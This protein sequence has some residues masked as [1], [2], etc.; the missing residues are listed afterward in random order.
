MRRIEEEKTRSIPITQA[1]VKKAYKKVRS[2]H[3]SAGVDQVSMEEYQA[4]LRNN[5]YKLWNRLSSG[6]YFPPPVQEVTIP[7]GNGKERKLGIPTVGDRVAQQV[8]KSYLEPILEAVFVDSSYGYRPLKSA[9]QAVE[10]VRENVRHYAWVID[11]DIKSFFD[12]IDHE[13]LMQALDRHVEERWVK[14]YVRRWLEAPVVDSTGELQAREGR[15]TPQGGVISPLLANLYLHYTFDK[16]M[17]LHHGA[18]P[19][20]RYADDIVV[21]CKSEEEAKETLDQIRT[22]LEACNL[23]LNEEKTKIVYCQNY[24]R[25][26]RHYRKRFDFLGFRFQPRSYPLKQG[27]MILGYDCGISPVSSKRIAKDWRALKFHRWIG[28]TLPELANWF[29]PKIRGLINY[30]CK[31]KWWELKNVIRVFHSRL[32]K[33]VLN[34]YKRFGR[35]YEKAHAWLVEVR[36]SFPTLFYHWSYGYKVT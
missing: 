9:H 36:R 25:E 8:I 3:G 24:R 30:Y 19:F 6:S 10:T 4:D 21:H 14:M 23:R 11:M 17:E 29:N 18:Q 33:W 27:G 35:S 28:I 5:Q 7:K 20:V 15:G 34:K 12:E 22:R 13:L 26:K 1:M 32:I 16:W 2:N 31:F